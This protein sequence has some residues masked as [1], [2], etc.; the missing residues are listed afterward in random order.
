ML[1]PVTIVKG[2]GIIRPYAMKM[3]RR[4]AKEMPPSGV[5]RARGA[6]DQCQMRT[7]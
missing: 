2:K 1:N 4:M 7:R 5:N 3:Q 6:G